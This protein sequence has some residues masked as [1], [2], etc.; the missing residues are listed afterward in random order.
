VLV[1]L[2]GGAAAVEMLIPAAPRG[3]QPLVGQGPVAAGTWYCPVTADLGESALLTVAAVGRAPSTVILTRYKDRKAVEDPPVVVAGGEALEVRLGTEDAVEPI[4]VR[5]QG[6]AAVAHWRVGGIAGIGGDQGD[7]AA[8]SCEP[9]PS[10]TWYLT[11]FDTTAKSRATLH[12]FNPYR[13]DAVA[14]LRF[15]TPKGPVNLVIADNQLVPAGTSARIDLSDFQ[16]EQPD[17]GVVVQALTG[18][19]VVQGQVKIEGGTGGRALLRGAPTPALEWA[20]AQMRSSE[21][22]SAWLSVQ[23][24]SD[25][26]AAVE[27]RVSDPRGDIAPLGETSVPA[28]GLVRI[29]LSEA[30]SQPDFGLAVTSLNEIP[31]VVS[32][33]W[34]VVNDKGRGLAAS[35]AAPGS[36]TEWA[37]AG[38]GTAGRSGVVSIY[39]PGVEDATVTVLGPKGRLREWSGLVVSPNRRVSVDLA[40]AGLDVAA[41]PVRVV[42]DR[43]VVTELSSL[44]PGEAPHLWAGVGVPAVDWTGPGTRPAVRLDPSL[45]TTPVQA[46]PPPTPPDLLSPADL[47][48]PPPAG[49]PPDPNTGGGD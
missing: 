13:E 37:L 21:S 6:G 46:P 22:S 19:L 27:V 25:R 33:F 40:A 45:A 41:I 48:P 36:S 5:W 32:A 31:V 39:N 30:S 35:L 26:E 49:P 16:P 29:D 20:V 28:G 1:V 18:R 42:S 44:D 34:T 8:A 3:D 2:I 10:Q 4:A 24:P 17:L 14:R 9:R 15:S 38:G 12:L 23:N 7:S 11:G 43:P 47:E